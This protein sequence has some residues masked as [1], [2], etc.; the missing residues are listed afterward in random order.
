MFRRTSA[1]TLIELLTVIAIIGILAA[2]LIPV[3]GNVRA[4]AR[5]TNCTSNVRQWAKANLLHAE[6]HD[7]KIPWDGG[8]NPNPA[9]RTLLE[10]TLPWWNALPPYVGLRPLSELPLNQLP[11][12]GDDSLFI[13]QEARP[14]TPAHQWLCYGPN[15]LLSSAG[16]SADRPRIT[17][18]GMIREPSRVAMFGE[19]TNYTPSSTGIFTNVNPVHLA[20]A[21]R[22][23]GRSPVAFFDGH[24]EVFT[25]AELTAQRP[26]SSVT[27]LNSRVIWHPFHQ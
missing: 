15:Y 25:S 4:A 20:N 21:T 6:D 1:F 27:Q 13:C 26:P 5:L 22:H 7:G 14:T 11:R 17:T 8:A 2:I 19:T 16:T 10:G 3:V 24:V 9:N 12:A 18:L 23:N